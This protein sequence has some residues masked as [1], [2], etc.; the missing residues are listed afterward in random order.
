MGRSMKGRP[1]G[2]LRRRVGCGLIL[3]AI[4]GVAGSSRAAEVTARELR[5]ACY[6]RAQRELMCTA[7]LTAR[8]CEH[9]ST[10]AFCDEWFWKERLPCWNWGYGG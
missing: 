7:D 3:I 10:H 9:R 6:C 5:G 8:E 1:A 4:A 2:A